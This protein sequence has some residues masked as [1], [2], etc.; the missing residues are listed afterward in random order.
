MDV[1][2]VTLP[3]PPKPRK[4]DSPASDDSLIDLPGQP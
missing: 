2:K 1:Y 4:A 3:A